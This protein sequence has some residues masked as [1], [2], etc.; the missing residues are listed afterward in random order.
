MDDIELRKVLLKIGISSN[1]IGYQFILEAIKI[2]KTQ[3]I[4]TNIIDVYE[5]ISI[6]TNS[7]RYYVER[8]IRNCIRSAYRRG[9]ALSKIYN[10]QPVNGAFLYDI[11]FNFDIF[12]E[13]N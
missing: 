4:H 3:Q 13:V 2:L 6:K 12:S 1:T 10:R 9:N 7:T 11:V 5:M 8:G